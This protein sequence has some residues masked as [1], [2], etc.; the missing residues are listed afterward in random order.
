MAE[1]GGVLKRRGEN[2]HLSPAYQTKC[3]FQ[4]HIINII[5]IDIVNNLSTC[6][7]SPVQDHQKSSL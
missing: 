5:N 7:K 2:N 3:S 1:E 6:F 4:H